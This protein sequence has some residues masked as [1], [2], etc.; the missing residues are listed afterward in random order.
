MRT[1]TRDEQKAINEVGYK[2]AKER[3]KLTTYRGKDVNYSL[4]RMQAANRCLSITTRHVTKQKLI[5]ADRDFLSKWLAD[6][7]GGIGDL[8]RDFIKALARETGRSVKYQ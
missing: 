7:E 3:Q 4:F 2:T 6:A 8:V 1:L 5:K